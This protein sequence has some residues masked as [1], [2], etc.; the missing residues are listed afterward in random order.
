[1]VAEIK[2]LEAY[3]AALAEN[4]VVIID[5]YAEWCGPCRVIAPKVVQFAKEY[6]NAAFFKVD[7]DEA[8][9]VAAELGVKA[10]PTFYLFKDSEKVQEVVGANPAALKAAIVK[11]LE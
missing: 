9:D 3:R 6:P 10:M 1:M 11:A 8:S 4:K 7:V 2:T 5:C